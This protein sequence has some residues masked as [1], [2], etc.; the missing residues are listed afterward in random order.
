MKIGPTVVENQSSEHGHFCCKMCT[1][2]KLLS[3]S[4][5]LGSELSSERLEP[6]VVIRFN[7][8]V[9]NDRTSPSTTSDHSETCPH[10]AIAINHSAMSTLPR[11]NLDTAPTEIIEEIYRHL[12]VRSALCLAGTCS[13]FYHIYQR[14][15]KRLLPSLVWNEECLQGSHGCNFVDLALAL[16]EAQQ[17]NRSKQTTTPNVCV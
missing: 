9:F 15:E 7:G 14:N 6:Y 3:Y 16:S 2:R 10:P 1:R 17:N 4:S 8:T 11:F 13:R 12:C 5:S